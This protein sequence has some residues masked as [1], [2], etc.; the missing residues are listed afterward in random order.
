MACSQFVLA[1]SLAVLSCNVVLTSLRWIVLASSL[2]VPIVP[3]L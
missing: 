2:A 3:T 1:S